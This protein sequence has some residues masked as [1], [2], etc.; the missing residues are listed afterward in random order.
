MIGAAVASSFTFA[1]GQAWLV[2]CQQMA[3]GQFLT[4][5]GNVDTSA[6]RDAFLNE[7]RKRMAPIRRR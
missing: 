1:L 4:G 3:S 5:N 7:F 6:V 2:V